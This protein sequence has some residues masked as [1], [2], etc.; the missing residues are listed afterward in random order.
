MPSA[1]R[2]VD[3]N[4]LVVFDAIYRARNLTAAGEAIGL[5]QP[6]M[7]HALARLRWMYKDP[8][9]VTRRQGLQPTPYADEM[10]PTVFQGLSAIR[11]TLEKAGFDPAVST[12]GFRLAMSDI[13]ERVLL[14]PLC[15]HLDAVAPGISI[16]TL[17]P[18]VRD[19][20]EA[21]SAGDIDL[22]FGAIP[23]LGPSFRQQLIYRS[24]YAC[25]VRAGHPTIRDTLTLR[26]FREG[27]HVLAVSK[28]TAH[29][30][31]VE[32]ALL[33]PNVKARI[34][35]RISHFLAIPGIVTNTDFIAT[36]PKTLAELFRQ[37][38][39]MRVLTPPV[40][41]PAFEIKLYWHERSHLDAGNKWLRGICA[42]VLTG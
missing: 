9:F 28:G 16:Q 6:A 23:E 27:V 10:A 1:N 33:A 17:Q 42:E 24:S 8:L 18:A 20:R 41:L 40:P 12:R 34:G 11:G 30:E 31:T 7:S 21:M 4:L 2:R 29:G 38:L 35:A 39:N 14:P 5:S 15:K 13:V 26:Q 19:M 36:I 32:R 22:A 25:V 37:T 3:L